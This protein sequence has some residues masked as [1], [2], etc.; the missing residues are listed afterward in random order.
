MNQNRQPLYLDQYELGFAKIS[1]LSRVGE[2]HTGGLQGLPHLDELVLQT[3][4]P[5]AIA[6]PRHAVRHRLASEDAFA[7]VQE[8]NSRSCHCL[9][10]LA[11]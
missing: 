6:V 4:T 11:T 1:L 7:R 10:A 5:C 2:M 3:A 9:S 8:H